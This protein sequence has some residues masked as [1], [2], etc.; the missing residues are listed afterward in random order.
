MLVSNG[1]RTVAAQEAAALLPS[2][3][4]QSAQECEATLLSD[5]IESAGGDASEATSD[6]CQI[7]PPGRQYVGE[8]PAVLKRQVLLQKGGGNGTTSS[9]QLGDTRKRSSHSSSAC[10]SRRK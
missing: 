8:E 6:N 9:R 3:M 1:K 4:P 2:H 7:T 10:S 5:V